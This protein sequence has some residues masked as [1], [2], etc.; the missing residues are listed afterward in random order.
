M[1]NYHTKAAKMFAALSN[2]DEETE[3]NFVNYFMRGIH[4]VKQGEILFGELMKRHDHKYIASD[5]RWEIQCAWEDVGNAMVKLDMMQQPPPSKQ[6]GN[7][8]A[9]AKRTRMLK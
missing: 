8:Q 7:T 2:V 3:E 5:R 9:A 4:Q 6:S 1:S